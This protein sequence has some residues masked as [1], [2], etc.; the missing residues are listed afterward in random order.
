[1]K[2]LKFTI[3]VICI[4]FLVLS[5][6]SKDDDS[7][8]GLGAGCGYLWSVR[9]AD[10]ITAL[11][12]AASAYSQDS[13]QAK[14]LEFKKA[15]NNYLDEAEDIKACVPVDDKDDFQKDIDEARAE[16]NDLPC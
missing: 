6:C 13:S 16:L 15:Y 8:L 3:P 7:P 1:M 4:S 9:I 14:C 11:S 10:E 2:L 5:S 12:Q